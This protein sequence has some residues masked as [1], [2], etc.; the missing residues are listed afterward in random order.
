M[1]IRESLQNLTNFL[2]SIKKENPETLASLI[3]T[4]ALN[5]EKKDI[6]KNYNKILSE[7]ERK[8][9]DELLQRVKNNEPIQYITERVH[10]FGLI[11]EIKP[12]VFIPRPETEILIETAINLFKNKKAI[13]FDIG[14]GSGVIGISLAKNLCNSFVYASDIIDLA[15]AKRNAKI[16]KVQNIKFIKASLFSSFKYKK[17]DLIISNPPYISTKEIEKL[18]PEIKFYEPHIAIDGGKDGLFF[19]RKIIK[20]APNYLKKD[21]KLL[22]EIDP[23]Q[24]QKIKKIANNYFHNIKFIKDYSKN[25]RAVLLN[26]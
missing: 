9:I 12:S 16:H 2:Y 11:F 6:F 18:Q 4:S 26:N 10:F 20:E 24:Q 14:T 8:K 5:I 19:I 25:T 22:L 21:G 23:R 3:L 17:A 13:I 1:L 15:L 7:K